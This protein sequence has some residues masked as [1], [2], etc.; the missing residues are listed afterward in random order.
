LITVQKVQ[1]PSGVP[2]SSEAKVL[3][4]KTLASEDSGT[5]DGG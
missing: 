3:I 5:V 2:E 4:S 1:P